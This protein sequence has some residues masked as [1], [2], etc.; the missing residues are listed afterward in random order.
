ME[1]RI[2]GIDFSDHRTL[3]SYY[4]DERNWN[5]PSVI[6]RDRTTNSWVI[7]Q[8]AYERVLSGNGILT[9]KLE[10]FLSKGKSCTLYGVYYDAIDILTRFF[11]EVIHST[12]ETG[13]GL[14]DSLVITIPEI[15]ESMVSDIKLCLINIGFD[16][17]CI[18]IISRAEAFIYY[19]MSQSQD[20]HNNNVGMFCLEDNNLTYY[21]MKTQ[22]KGKATFAFADKRLLDESFNLDLTHTEAGAK[23]A[24]KIL[25]NS[26]EALLKNKIYSCIILT[27]SG[28]TRQE[29]APEFMKYICTKR[30]VFIEDE[31]F[32][33]GAG[34]KG[35]DISSDKP[36]FNFTAIC[37]GHIDSSIYI[38][39]N[40][41]DGVVSYPIINIGD[42]W[43]GSDKIIRV[44]P[45]AT[46]TIDL[47]ILPMEERRRKIISMPLDF[48]P[49]RPPKTSVVFIKIHFKNA[50]KAEIEMIDTGFGELYKATGN[51]YTQEVSLWD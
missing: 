1:K 11:D 38:S 25:L 43:Y 21:E 37:D 8:S 7:G 34:Y 50:S 31:I 35:A 15:T 44:I 40:K 48:L 3:L 13:E 2:L 23:L 51:K 10:S 14:P 42:K 5:Y 45:Y 22:R 41:K 30:K 12:L 27:G 20:L 39:I 24:D 47:T 6:C 46:K 49:E 17:K 26:A 9:D 33:R 19:V 36:I 29:W 32:S 16:E 28:F 4:S 18:H